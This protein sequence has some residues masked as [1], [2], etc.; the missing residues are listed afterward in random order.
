MFDLIGLI[1]AAGYLGIAGVLFAESGLF[2]GF[3]LPGDSLLFTAG[4]LA[5]RGFLD[6]RLLIALSFA[7]AV[8]GDN[9]GYA[10]GRRVGPAIFT[11]E[12]SLFFNKK[13]LERARRFYERH[14]RKTIVLARFLPFVR[15]FAPILAGVGA[16]RY[17]TFFAYNLAGGAVWTAGLPLLG[18][19]LG[20]AIPDADRYLVP[21]IGAIVILSIVPNLAYFKR[22]A[23]KPDRG[24]EN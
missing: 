18:F 16:M 8:L 5:S 15:T 19:Y 17:K 11:K 4:F 20:N 6:I 3:F 12:E 1:R 7:A 10:F 24:G 2:V 23:K 13:Y 21:I 14:G 22:L 9:F